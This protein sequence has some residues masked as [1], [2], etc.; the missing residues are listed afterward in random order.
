MTSGDSFDLEIPLIKSNYSRFFLQKFNCFT[1][2]K[3]A[4]ISK[5]LFNQRYWKE[6]YDRASNDFFIQDV[7]GS[8]TH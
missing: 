4:N 2:K 1:K 7:L 5:I 3:C 8:V 6:E